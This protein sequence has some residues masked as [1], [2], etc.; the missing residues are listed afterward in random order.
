AVAAVGA[1]EAPRGDAGLPH[2]WVM[3]KGYAL[4]GRPEIA[5]A[6][7]DRETPVWARGLWAEQKGLL[8][9]ALGLAD[10]GLAD[11]SRA[12]AAVPGYPLPQWERGLHLLE[13]GD[14]RGALNLFDRSRSPGGGALFLLGAAREE[15]NDRTGA[16]RAYGE[17]AGKRPRLGL[18]YYGLGRA[19]FLAKRYNEALRY[20]AS[21]IKVSPRLPCLYLQRA[22]VYERLKMRTQAKKD[23][24]TAAAIKVPGEAAG[25]RLQA[26]SGPAR[27][28]VMVSVTGGAGQLRGLFLSRDGR[29][30]RW[31]AWHLTPVVLTG[32]EPGS[33][34]YCLPD[35]GGGDDL[36]LA[37]V[38]A[39]P[40]GASDGAPSFVGKCS[41]SSGEE[42]AWATWRT[43]EPTRA[44]ITVWE[45]GGRE[46][47]GLRL[48]VEE[49]SLWH[50]F[51]L[52]DLFPREYC[53]RVT[54][55]DARGNAVK[56]EV[57]Y[58]HP[59]QPAATLQGG[60]R[61]NNGEP[62]T[63]QRRVTL[64]LSLEGETRGCSVRICN[65]NGLFS[66]WLPFAPVMSWELSPGDGPK[67]VSAQFRKGKAYSRIYSVE[68][69][70]DT[71]PPFIY[72]LLTS[73]VDRDSAVLSWQTD[74]PAK[75]RLDLAQGGGW[76]TL[77]LNQGFE[78]IHKARLTGLQPGTKYTL[79]LIAQDRA[80]NLS[81]ATPAE[82]VTIAE[83]D[84]TPP[85]GWLQVN[86]G[87]AYTNTVNVILAVDGADE[88]SGIKEMSFS[89]DGVLWS[90]REP[91]ARTKKWRLSPGDGPK[92]VFLKLT[93][94]AGN[95]SAAI[96]A[97][98][99]LDTRPPEIRGVQA[100]QEADARVLISWETDESSY[101]VAQLG[102]NPY[103]NDPSP[104]TLRA[105]DY[106]RYHRLYLT[107]PAGLK[108]VY[109]R[110]AAMDQAGNVVL[111]PTASLAL[112]RPDR[113]GPAGGLRIN[114]GQDYTAEPDVVLTLWAEDESGV[115]GMRL[116][117]ADGPWGPWE[118]FATKRRWM[119]SRGEGEKEV[120]VVYRDVHG[121]ESP[122][123]S[124]RIR[125]V[126]RPNPPRDITWTQTGARSAVI[127]WRTDEPT[128]GLVYYRRAVGGSE[129]RQSA[130]DLVREHEVS[131]A[132]LEPE[133]TYRVRVVAID[134]SGRQAESPVFEL[135]LT[136]VDRTKPSGSIAINNGADYANNPRVT[137]A[138]SATDPDGKVVAMSF[139]NDGRIWSADEPYQ[140][141]KSYTLPGGDGLK[142]IY[143]RFRDRAGNYSDPVSDG[144]ILDTKP[145]LITDVAVDQGASGNAVEIRWRTDEPTFGVVRFGGVARSYS[146]NAEEDRSRL[147]E[148]GYVHEH[149]VRLENLQPG[150]TYYAAIEAF[151]RADN[152]S[153]SP[154]FKFRAGG[155]DQ[156]PPSGS[157]AINNGADYTNNPQVTLTLSASDPDGR[158]AAMSFSN[159]GRT[160]SADEP[161][162]ASRPYTLPGGDGK[163]TVFVRFRD[164][165][166]NYSGPAQDSIVLD[167]AP[168]VVS[169]VVVREMKHEVE[170][171]WRTNE[172]AWCEVRYGRESKKHDH[173]ARE[174][175]GREENAY[176]LEHRIVLEDIKQG[177]EYYFII[178]A[179][180]RAGNESTSP[181]G[182]FGKGGA[183]P[184]APEP[185][186]Q[187]QPPPQP[188][189]QPQPA[190]GPNP[191]GGFAS[192]ANAALAANGGRVT[193]SP[194]IRPKAGSPPGAANDGDHGT[195]WF[196]APVA[197]KLGASA[198][199]SAQWQ[200]EF[201]RPCRL[202][203]LHL[204]LGGA[205]ELIVEYR[206][207]GRWVKA[208]S[209]DA[210]RPPSFARVLRPGVME[211]NYTLNAEADAVRLTWRGLPRNSEIRL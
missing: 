162:Q 45:R 108:T 125:L 80:G 55:I 157:I 188:K 93:D 160:W 139:S 200:V 128:T 91:F 161:Y 35:L 127:R 10:G 47:N 202:A 64:A 8:G 14:A 106:A 96:G 27:G 7:L 21:G 97:Q 98:I 141:V 102:A 112:P 181:E 72:G 180:D 113:Q 58:A 204:L 54:I 190:P 38:V 124:A 138:L 135:T 170:I 71:R 152:R 187:P 6:V 146:M 169:G 171:V 41:V 210:N 149:R 30:W 163:K 186:P 155:G 126:G 88:G 115:G 84:R 179:R 82:I 132:N 66:K 32:L 99:Y 151:D 11:L 92:T 26:A 39:A 156:T 43:D 89:N 19:Y 158:V 50:W 74:E 195:Y 46:E 34:L 130:P 77:S 87:Q 37:T 5:A 191:G 185:Q 81:Q 205:G 143:A 36:L 16:A 83:A 12:S 209:C 129:Y 57:F 100:R 178:L 1:A 199:S 90:M 196:Y 94:R 177:W 131:L 166:G 168:P 51:F 49:Y 184:P 117:N 33:T 174:K 133:T 17:L 142:R 120:Q 29:R 18:A 20:L 111:S 2:H 13:Q 208:F 73:A 61:I 201:K 197:A 172:P 109:C 147:P 86:N 62:Y 69:V 24:D 192:G 56:S 145:P 40:P 118:E 15:A 70:L 206:Q 134:R 28:T 25:W 176:T 148:G 154:E 107:A 183:K 60:A 103:F 114:D 164:Q 116:R 165:A 198:A 173:Q 121:N 85:T 101:G 189:P 65:E 79:R 136:A 31:Y 140:A 9:P 68:V 203:R 3:A 23:R 104:E 211:L 194:M 52:G 44:E 119:L 63:N 159:D 75:C 193:A 182:H 167:T 122:V 153:T 150:R 48:K 144:I 175:G 59:G 207:G 95:E 53:L 76:T 22:E 78:E 105:T 123:Y 42:G 137:L 4:M 67:T 110:V